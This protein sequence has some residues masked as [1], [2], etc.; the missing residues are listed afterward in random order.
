[1]WITRETTIVAMVSKSGV[2][3]RSSGRT[4]VDFRTDSDVRVIIHD[5]FGVSKI[6]PEAI[7][8]HIS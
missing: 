6:P 7:R 8:G 2:A 1:M 3:S 5:F 4:Q